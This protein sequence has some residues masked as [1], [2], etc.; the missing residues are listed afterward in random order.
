MKT[1]DNEKDTAAADL[2][3]A[4]DGAK[5]PSKKAAKSA[6]VKPG[7][8][9]REMRIDKLRDL[10]IAEAE[11]RASDR[12]TTKATKDAKTAAFQTELRVTRSNQDAKR[13]NCTHRKGGKV[14]GTAGIVKA[15][16][17][18]SSS[19]Y[20]LITHTL[21]VGNKVIICQRCGTEWAEPA[22]E[23]RR[24]N[25]AEYKRLLEEFQHMENLPTD[26]EPSGTQIFLVERAA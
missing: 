12:A 3:L 18:G 22:K 26:N 11:Q 7:D 8:K 2:A 1:E 9:D 16:N 23:M 20:A 17:K 25:P 10:Q 5:G 24:T 4:T 19:D 14:A 15:I 6:A 21:P 13:K